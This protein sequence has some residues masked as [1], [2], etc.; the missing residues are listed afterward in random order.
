MTDKYKFPEIDGVIEWVRAK[1]YDWTASV[2]SC[3]N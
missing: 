3:D 2:V 1:P